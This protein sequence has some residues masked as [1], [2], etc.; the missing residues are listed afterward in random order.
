MTDWADEK[1]AA[2][3]DAPGILQVWHR[4]GYCRQC[5]QPIAGSA[6]DLSALKSAIATALRESRT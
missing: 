2:I 3:V 6:L 4:T 5:R 1:A